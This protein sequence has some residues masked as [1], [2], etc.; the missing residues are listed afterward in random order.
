MAVSVMMLLSMFAITL[1][2][3]VAFTPK[4]EA[5]GYG[6]Y[7][8][9]YYPYNFTFHLN[10]STRHVRTDA[11]FHLLL[12]DIIELLTDLQE[13]LD[14][15]DF[16][17]DDDDSDSEVDVATRPA[18]RIQDDHARI[19]G[20]VVDFNESNYATV[21]LQY[22]RTST[23]LTQTTNNARID[24]DEDGEFEGV[25]S[26]LSEGQRYY[27]RAVA[28]DDD[29]DRDYG[30]VLHFIA[31]EASDDDDD[32]DDSDDSVPDVTTDN[33]DDVTDDSAVLNGS[34]DMN[35]FDNGEVFFVY[36]EDEELVEEVAD[37]FDSYGDV[38]EE[39]DDLQKVLVDSSLDGDDDYDTEINGLNDDTDYYFSLCVGYEDDGDDV[40]ECGE[41][42][43]FTTDN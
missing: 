5:A 14:D 13:Q 28:A 15:G 19:G 8:N 7:Y 30:S 35:D 43:T 40:I 23:G 41:V 24:D 3:S 4:V 33:E 42:R 2:G 12:Q 38:D 25:I 11:D 18:T 31:G 32:S 1:L 39:S 20:E 34:V 6:G 16:I 21:W 37:E 29:G 17:D 36:G 9:Y 10:G 26:N 22:G 27:F